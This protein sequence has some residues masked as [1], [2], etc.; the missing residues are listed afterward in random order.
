MKVSKLTDEIIDYMLAMNAEDNQRSFYFPD[1]R[2]EINELVEEGATLYVNYG[3]DDS[4]VACAI[5]DPV[6]DNHTV[7]VSGPFGDTE[8]RMGILQ[9]IQED[10]VDY[11]VLL[12][13][14]KGNELCGRCSV[15]SDE[16]SMEIQAIGNPE[17]EVCG[18]DAAVD[19]LELHDRMFPNTYVNAENLASEYDILV[20]RENGKPAGY[21][22]YE[23]EENYIDFVAVDPKYRR[24]G[25][26]RK[27][28]NTALYDMQG[29]KVRLTVASDNTNAIALYWA[30]G[31]E[32]K[33]EMVSSEYLG[34]YAKR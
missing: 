15:L 29:S 6:K 7:E 3:P 4:I 14:A 24:R 25:I 18:Y 23:R 13:L 20:Y 22:A 16:L 12:F 31:F 5:A 26:A 33:A 17:P 11:K 9:K 32:V 8:S 1:D 2:E 27:L 30:M 21:V 19:S 34:K 10:F 28:L